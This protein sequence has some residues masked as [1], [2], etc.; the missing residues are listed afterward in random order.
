[1]YSVQWVEEKPGYLNIL[2]NSSS[3]LLKKL[4]ISSAELIYPQSDP[5]WTEAHLESS[6]S[7]GQGSKHSSLVGQSRSSVEQIRQSLGDRTAAS[8]S[9]SR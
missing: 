8:G 6:S 7:T 3:L 4:K 5:P 2:S 1:M 9:P